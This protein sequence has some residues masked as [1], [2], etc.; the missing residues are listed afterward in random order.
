MLQLAKIYQKNGISNGKTMITSKASYVGTHL[1]ETADRVRKMFHKMRG[2]IIIFDEAGAL[3]E[4][5]HY[6]NEALTEIVRFMEMYPDVI[7]FFASYPENIEKLLERDDGLRSRI[8]EVITLEDYSDEELYEILLKFCKEERYI[9]DDCYEIFR[10]FVE[11]KRKKYKKSFG[12]ARL[13][14]NLFEK[15]KEFVAMDAFQQEVAPKIVDHITRKQ[16]VNGI[17]ALEENEG[18]ESKNIMKIG[19]KCEKETCSC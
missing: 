4:D 9:I 8:S 17:Q 14:R 13:V 6:T 5:D 15:T 16:F 2:G 1:G 3:L 18:V 10:E 11:K 19:F 12:N 7:C